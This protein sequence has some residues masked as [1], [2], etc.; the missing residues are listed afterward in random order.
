MYKIL[1]MILCL[2]RHGLLSRPKSNPFNNVGGDLLIETNLTIII[3]NHINH[4]ILYIHTPI[5]FFPFR[6]YQKQYLQ[7]QQVSFTQYPQPNKWSYPAFPP[8]QITQPQQLQLPSNQPTLRPTQLPTQPVENPKNK[9]K[10][11]FII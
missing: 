7:Q 6:K 2:G 4:Q 1:G 8:P 9:V 5:F 11:L 10:N 3:K